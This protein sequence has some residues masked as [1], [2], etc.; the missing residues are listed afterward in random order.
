MVA[1]S[2]SPPTH[3]E[4]HGR[5]VVGSLGPMVAAPWVSEDLWSHKRAQIRGSRE[6]HGLCAM[7]ACAPTDTRVMGPNAP[8]TNTPWVANDPPTIPFVQ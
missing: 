2:G 7:G 5:G 4:T 6:T 3:P 1:P 8:M